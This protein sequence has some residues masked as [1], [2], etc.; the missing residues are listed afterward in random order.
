MAKVLQP[1]L[2]RWDAIDSAG[3]LDRLSLAL[4]HLPDEKIILALTLKRGNG[5]ND[6]PIRPMWNA[7]IAGIVFQHPSIAALLREL[8]RNGQL[9]QVCGFN[10]LL[11]A[12]A[13]PDEHNMSRFL[14]NVIALEALIREMFDTLLRS[15]TALLPSLG[16]RLAFDGKAIPSFST[17][18]KNRHTGETSDP[19]ADHGIKTYGGV[20]ADGT[21]WK[22]IVHW[23]GYQ[24]HLIVDSVH[25]LP[26]AYE[27]HKASASETTRLLPLVNELAEK[28]PELIER[29][30]ELAADRGLDSAENN[31]AL[32]HAYGI[33]PIIDNRLLWRQEKDEPG[34]D[35]TKPIT[36]PLDPQRVDCIVYTEKGGIFCVCPAMGEQRA[37]AFMGFEKD[38]EC[39]KYRCPAAAY[40]FACAGRTDCAALSGGCPGDFGRIVRVALSRDYRIFVPTPRDSPS[41]ERA[42]AKRTAVERVNSRIDNVFGFENH[43]IRGLEKMRT[44]MGL[45]MVVLLAM[46]VGHL[47]AG[48]NNQIRSLVRPIPPAQTLKQAA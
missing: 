10:P 36:R 15:A 30:E 4:N 17:G 19:D 27:L 1:F 43:T 6:F 9:R 8:R 34:Y 33:R 23:F 45:A 42:Y 39:L 13:V 37:M 20:H 35:P 32:L 21:A 31:R 28:H 48:R 7:L 14:A 25:E 16:E 41:F 3:D 38:R 26:V 47:Q 5:R 40:G 2:L 29:T 46:A 22:K 12:G 44:R 24:L 11:G 18:H